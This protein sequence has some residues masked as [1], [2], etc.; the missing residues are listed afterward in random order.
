MW[1]ILEDSVAE[2]VRQSLRPGATEAE[3]NGVENQ[4]DL[5]LPEQLR[6]LWRV[7]DGQQLQFDTELD[8]DVERSGDGSTGFH[9]SIGDGLFGGYHVYDHWVNTRLMPLSRIERWSGDKLGGQL[10]HAQCVIASSFNLSKIVALDCSTSE[11]SV[12]R[13]PRDRFPRLSLLTRLLHFGLLGRQHPWPFWSAE[14]ILLPRWQ[15]QQ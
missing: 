3:L 9:K 8:A 2:P 12:V 14:I 4:L 7:H 5:V 1:R 13:V 10:G 11:L 6:A 15:P